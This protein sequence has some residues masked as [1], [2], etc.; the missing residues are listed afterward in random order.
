MVWLRLDER[1]AD[2]GVLDQALAVGDA[3]A[4]RVADR[5]GGAGLRCRDHQVGLDGVLG[6]QPPAD[7]DAGGVHGAAGD[8]GVGAGEVD[9]LE[10]AALRLR[11]RRTGSCGCR[12]VVDR[13]QLAGLDL[14]HERGADDVQRRRLAR[15]HPAALEASEDERAD[16]V[17]VAGGVE[18]VLVGE[19]QRVGP[20]QPREQPHRRLLDADVGGRGREQL[21]DQV[22]VG[23]RAHAAAVVQRGDLVAQLGGVDEVAVV[24]ERDAAARRGG[25]ER[26]LGVLPG[27]GAGGGVAAVADRDVPRQR[28]RAPARRRPG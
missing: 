14:A 20:A 2:V 7:L 25:A 19:D 26:R 11:R 10:H 15:D 17:R 5:G 4:L 24:A 3:G 12:S 27:G 1:A 8:R 18:R 9:V 13:D 23:A 28:G 22:G 16:A 21:G 6:G